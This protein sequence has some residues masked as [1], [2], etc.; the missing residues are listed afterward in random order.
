MGV[1][2]QK[3]QVEVEMTT[4]GAVRDA[5]KF[6]DSVEKS[7]KAVEKQDKEL[8]RA[9]TAF[10]VQ[11]ARTK[12]L[13]DRVKAFERAERSATAAAEKHRRVIEKQSKATGGGAVSWGRMARGAGRAAGAVGVAAVALA[14]AAKITA[15]LS[16]ESVKVSGVFKNLP[17]SLNAA[18][19]ST[20]G[21]ADDMTLA[22]N[23][24]L[25]NQSGIAPTS[26]K[27]AELVG[28][29]QT[30][31]LK[32]GRDV[33]E[34]VERVTQGIAKQEREILDE[35]VVLPKLND[36]LDEFAAKNN[37][38]V[39]SLSAEERQSAFT[40]SAFKALRE[41]TKGVN[42]DMDGFAGAVSRTVVEMKNLKTQTLGGKEASVSLRQ[43]LLGLDAATLKLAAS[44]DENRINE[45]LVK[46]A[47]EDQGVAADKLRGGNLVLAKSID[48]ILER[49]AKRLGNRADDKA[50]TEDQIKLA[51]D[52]I[53]AGVKFSKVDVKLIARE[54]ERLGLT[55]EQVAVRE[56]LAEEDQAIVAF[57]REA[58]LE[59]ENEI[60]LLRARGAEETE[61]NALVVEQLELKSEILE[62]EGDLEGAAKA[63]RKAEL[64]A[65]RAASGGRR[66]RGGRRGKSEADKRLEEFKIQQKAQMTL[67]RQRERVGELN[68]ALAKRQRDEELELNPFS[69]ENVELQLANV[70]DLGERRAK[71][72]L[73]Q[74]LRAV[75][76][77]R[78]Q[79]VEPIELAELESAAKIQGIRAVQ[80]AKEQAIQREIELA[81]LVGTEAEVQAL[82]EERR[83][84][85]AEQL[86][87]IEQ[88]LHELEMARIAERDAAESKTLKKRQALVK[89]S[90]DLWIAG[91]ESVAKANLISGQSLKKAV[92]SVAKAKALE[93]GILAVSEG[94]KAA[95]AFASFDFI[96]G[97]AH[98][99]NAAVSAAFAAGAAGVAAAAGGFGG[100]GGGVSVPGGSLSGSS[101]A[102][103]PGGPLEADAF[104]SGRSAQ[105]GDGAGGDADL[106]GEVPIS[107]A[108]DPLDTSGQASTIGSASSVN[109][110]QTININTIGSINE[111]TIFAISKGQRKAGNRVGKLAAGTAA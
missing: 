31:A 44:V 101:R 108:G 5:K 21:L 89:R 25:A 27:Y 67:F 33:S 65:I 64:A 13:T 18:R 2:K 103:G 53:S 58:L 6:T 78:S 60:E 22:T 19:K 80:A 15:D 47:L 81:I 28:I 86:N 35:L 30:L 40:E 20:K 74:R 93:H 85:A 17:F 84:S 96:R 1:R 97:A 24:I 11:T 110:Q 36:V 49:E 54:R 75:D 66:G 107:P 98:L 95:I 72:D 62:A 106:G 3:I 16:E 71:I 87:D 12:N 63:R 23:A 43:G 94:I 29:A 109:V 104:G 26:A 82:R 32:M 83:I 111:E 77:L 37:K 57:K 105:V 59:T 56:A 69:T 7:R 88:N 50:L 38:T 42:V 51:G 92:A 100:A 45:I 76:E 9:S 46:E 34:T 73:D 48:K 8:K 79:G 39:D 14:G 91:A 41:A 70:I 90:S 4:E 52:L 55:K 61:I 68:I 10:L 99:T 102:G